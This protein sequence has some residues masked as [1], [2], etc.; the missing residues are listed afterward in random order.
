MKHFRGGI[1]RQKCHDT[2]PCVPFLNAKRHILH[3]RTGRIARQD[4]TFRGPLQVNNRRFRRASGRYQGQDCCAT[5]ANLHQ[6]PCLSRRYDSAPFSRHLPPK[7]LA[8]AKTR[9]MEGHPR[10]R[11]N[12]RYRLLTAFSRNKTAT[13]NENNRIFALSQAAPRQMATSPLAARWHCLCIRMGD[14]SFEL[15]ACGH[16]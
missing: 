11:I 8:A 2:F 6:T 14:A 7:G 15:A 12:V 3:G 10:M 1:Y 16:Q 13:V 4:G 9:I 5:L